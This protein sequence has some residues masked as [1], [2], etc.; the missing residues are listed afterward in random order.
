PVQFAPHAA[1]DVAHL[2]DHL[3]VHPDLD[4]GNVGLSGADG[5]Q[6][7]L[8]VVVAAQHA[9]VVG[10]EHGSHQRLRLGADAYAAD[11]D[12]PLGAEQDQTNAHALYAFAKL[13]LPIALARRDQIHK[14]HAHTVGVL[15]LDLVGGERIANIMIDLA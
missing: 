12:P 13:E 1:R 7:I 4:R 5:V 10:A 15:V 2:T 9:D 6:Q 11:P 14:L 3:V 8:A